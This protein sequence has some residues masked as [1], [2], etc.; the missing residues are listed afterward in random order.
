MCQYGAAFVGERIARAHSC[1]NFGH[2]DAAFSSEL[3]NFAERNLQVFLN[4]VAKGLE[5]RDIKHFSSVKQFPAERFP[6]Q[7]IYANEKCGQRLTRTCWSGNECSFLSENTRP[8]H[9]LRFR[10]SPE[11]R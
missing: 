2:E 1:A 4:V 6:D 7:A 3:Q 11:V 9:L 10:R 8:T 5:R